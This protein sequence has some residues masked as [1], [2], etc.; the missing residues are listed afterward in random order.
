MKIR[1]KRVCTLAG[2]L[3]F[4]T[5]LYGQVSTASSAAAEK[6][7]NGTDDSCKESGGDSVSWSCVAPSVVF[8]K[9]KNTTYLGQY[10]THEHYETY[11]PSWNFGNDGGWRIQKNRDVSGTFAARGIHQMYTSSSECHAVGDCA[12]VYVYAFSDG[13]IQGMSDEGTTMASFR[14]GETNGYFHG[15]VTKGAP[16]STTPTLAFTS[17]NNWT[18][19]GAF[20]L[21]LT[22]GS[23]S[24]KLTAYSTPLPAPFSGYLASLGVDGGLPKTTAWGAVVVKSG[25]DHAIPD[26][27]TT[28]D[29]NVP[30]TLNVVLQPVSG[31]TPAFHSGGTVCVAGSEYPEQAPI[32]FA[33][34]VTHGVQ[35]ITI[36]V[37]NPNPLAAIFQGGICGQYISLDANVAF[38]GYRTAY[39]AFG[40]LTGSDLIYGNN[41]AGGLGK[42]RIPDE[43]GSEIASIAAP[44]NGFHLYPGAEVVMNT[45]L[46]ANPALEP[47]HVNWVAG[48]VVEN[49]H[50][51]TVGGT[52][53]IVDHT[54]NS[55]TNSYYGAGAL[56]LTSRG[57]GVSGP[58]KVIDVLNTLNSSSYHA[59]GGPLAAPFLFHAT[60]SFSDLFHFI[61]GPQPSNRGHNAVISIDETSDENARPF[62]LFAL[63]GSNIEYDPG[64][65]T[66]SFQGVRVRGLKARSGTRF[67]CVDTEGNLT[68]SVRPCE[69]S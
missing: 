21:D 35:S 2:V 8:S 37:R 49:P 13:G 3:L 10:G 42:R 22:K 30:I 63:P 6:S 55:P 14:G 29:R 67:V 46:G 1:N 23:A 53:V 33:G 32:T 56:A 31:G 44:N 9:A 40:S 5:A 69:G 50:F 41:I 7:L 48:D 43:F 61:T 26:P 65:G 18:T 38:T 54:Q 52:G 60:G 59:R 17:G 68:S 36:S 34:T 58:Y 39:Y 15:K 62:N 25:D 12:G 20:L 4:S 66:T 28:A 19:D 64:S 16:G 24:G 11:G 51:Q 47:N 45:S 57:F 27:H